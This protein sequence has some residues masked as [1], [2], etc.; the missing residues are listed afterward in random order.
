MGV[1]QVD[2]LP[3]EDRRDLIAFEE[4]VAGLEIAVDEDGQWADRGIGP[5]PSDDDASS[6]SGSS[7]TRRISNSQ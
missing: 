4:D 1:S 3:V 5:E 2:R 7:C 6:G